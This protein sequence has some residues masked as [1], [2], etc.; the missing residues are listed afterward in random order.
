MDADRTDNPWAAHRARARELRE[1]YP[2]AVEVLDLYLALLEVWDDAFDA[3]RADRPAP[4]R[5][6]AWAVDR[7]L[8]AVL[9]AT[10]ASGP[11]SLAAAAGGLLASGR[12]ESVLAAWLAGDDLDPVETYLA[13]ASL[14]APLL[15]LA[16]DAWSGV[17]PGRGC[18]RCG[19]T[20]QVSERGQSEDRLVSGRRFL[21]CARCAHSWPFSASTCPACGESAG[22][23]RTVYSEQ[24][25]G[26]VVGRDEG[27]PDAEPATFPHVRIDACASLPAVHHRR[28][29]QSGHP[30]R[31]R[32]GRAGGAT[33]GPVRR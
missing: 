12:M 25:G 27:D 28:G 21:I 4:V 32:G 17:E 8:P 5:L 6:A 13:R 20:A 3:V 33:A 26:P 22:A 14:Y 11:E 24:R 1:R 19:G 18:P 30:G 2:F 29:S 23:R 9:K 7:V 31:A 10:G 16:G 15:A